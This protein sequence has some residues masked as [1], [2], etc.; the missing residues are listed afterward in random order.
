MLMEIKLGMSFGHP[1]FAQ[2]YGCF[3]DNDNLYIVK[4]YLEEGCMT[5]LKSQMN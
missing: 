4:E 3:S 5:E 1:N 2:V